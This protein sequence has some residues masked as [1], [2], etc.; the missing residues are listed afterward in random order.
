MT[1][2]D[3]LESLTWGAE[4]NR[5]VQVYGIDLMD[6]ISYDEIVTMIDRFDDTDSS[7][8]VLDAKIHLHEHNETRRGT[9]CCSR[10][11]GYLQITVCSLLQERAMG[12]VTRY[13][14]PETYWNAGFVM[15]G[16]T[17]G[18]RSILMTSSRRNASGGG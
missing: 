5:A 16:R 15:T 2:T 11:F 18:V 17:D 9:S 6:D 14:R 3:I 12:Q 13:T 4:G 8:N 7:M 1:E 10:G